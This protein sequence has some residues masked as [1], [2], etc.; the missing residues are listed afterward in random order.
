MTAWLPGQVPWCA[1]CLSHYVNSSADYTCPACEP[2]RPCPPRS[3]FQQ[4]P[5]RAPWLRMG[6]AA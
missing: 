1:L 2:E 6:G 3:V 5:T 4:T